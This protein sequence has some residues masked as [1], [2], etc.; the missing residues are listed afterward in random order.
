MFSAAFRYALIFSSAVFPVLASMV[1]SASIVNL[2][3]LPFTKSETRGRLV[4]KISAACSCFKFRSF[5]HSL[6]LSANFI[7]IAARGKNKKAY[8]HKKTQKSFVTLL[9]MAE[10]LVSYGF[11]GNK[12]HILTLLPF[13][14]ASVFWM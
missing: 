12:T 6:M 13:V 8:I 14:T 4:L 11:H 7:Q 2:L 3:I 1:N 5:I 9:P 10:S